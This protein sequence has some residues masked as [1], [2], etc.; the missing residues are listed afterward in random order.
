M[1][2]SLPTT[3]ELDNTKIRA[4]TRKVNINTLYTTYILI[5]ENIFS[6]LDSTF[7]K[8]NSVNI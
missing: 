2:L 6:E 1:L 7:I 8:I 5:L 4:T 3:S